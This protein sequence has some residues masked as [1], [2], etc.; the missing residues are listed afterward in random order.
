VKESQSV[1][2]LRGRLA[3]Y[4]RWAVTEDR[5]AAT[6][7]AR[8]AFIARFQRQVDPAGRLE[9]AERARRAEFALH[10]YMARLAMESVKARRRKASRLDR[11]QKLAAEARAGG[12]AV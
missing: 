10:A 3:A 4:S 9:P 11:T 6:L 5:P 2:T 12:Q 1:A 8:T 7:P